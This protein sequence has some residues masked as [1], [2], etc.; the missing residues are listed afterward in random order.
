MITIDQIAA[1]LAERCGMMQY[2]IE[3][4]GHKNQWLVRMR[5]TRE[6]AEVP[7]HRHEVIV[8]DSVGI[9]GLVENL[10]K[11]VRAKF[12]AERETREASS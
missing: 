3:S 6:W 4:L 1:A 8:A 9:E 2:E 7:I 12:K 11:Q 5:N 10:A